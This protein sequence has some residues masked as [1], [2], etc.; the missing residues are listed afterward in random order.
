VKWY[1]KAGE[2]N[3]EFAQFNL[4]KCYYYGQGVATDCKAAA[5]LF[6]KSAEQNDELPNAILATATSMD[7]A[8]LVLVY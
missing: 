7:A 6:R 8:V 1:R 2:Q 5:E 4:G 3:D